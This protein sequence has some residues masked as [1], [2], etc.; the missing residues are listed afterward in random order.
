MADLDRRKLLRAGIAFALPMGGIALLGGCQ[1]TDETVDDG[2]TTGGESPEKKEPEKPEQE[3]SKSETKGKSMQLQYLEIVTSDAERLC[4]YYASIHGITFSEPVMNLGN[5]R[6]AKM[7]GGTVLAIRGP[8]RESEAPAIR[9]YTLVDDVEKAVAAAKEAGA[10][11]AIPKMEIPE[12][13]TIAIVI[14]DGI[15]CGL[16]QN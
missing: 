8:M 14:I 11:I 12:H 16:W 3:T 6:T 4:Q 13:G 9:P 1:P 2:K 15:E 7:E 5:A 10:E